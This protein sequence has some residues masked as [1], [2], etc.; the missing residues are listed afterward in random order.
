MSD[1]IAPLTFW[2]LILEAPNLN[3]F[4]I[5]SIPLFI[6]FYPNSEPKAFDP[7]SS[8]VFARFG[9]NPLPDCPCTLL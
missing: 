9:D 5:L 8:P 4:G 6:I 1:L 2:F 7:G 3:M